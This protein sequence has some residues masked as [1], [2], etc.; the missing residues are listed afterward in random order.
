MQTQPAAGPQ[1]AA[2]FID[3]LLERLVKLAR[4][5]A[6]DGL[7]ATNESDFIS[8][9][10]RQDAARRAGDAAEIAQR[11]EWN[12]AEMCALINERAKLARELGIT[13]LRAAGIRS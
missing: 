4:I 11:L 10:H 9:M 13:A 6:I 7:L 12:F 1:P 8:L 2:T 3:R 5:R